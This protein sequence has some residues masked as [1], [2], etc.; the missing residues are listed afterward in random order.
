MRKTLIESIKLKKYILKWPFE[1]LS[2]RMKQALNTMVCIHD[3]KFDKHISRELKERG[4]WEPTNIR[5]FLNLLNDL[6]DTNVI[7]V[8]ANIGVYSLFAA[9]LGRNVI[10]VEPLHENLNRLHK[11]A[12]LEG[13][14]PNSKI[15]I[16]FF[17]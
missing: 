11:A 5:S 7:D 10:A 2:T 12:Q 9:K 17:Y 16:D 6:N 4:M 1:C 14:V 13:R 3:P 15:Y 8:G